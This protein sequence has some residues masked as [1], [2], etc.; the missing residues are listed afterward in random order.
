VAD[1]V[2]DECVIVEVKALDQLHPVHER[3]LHTY[4]KIADCRLGL[5]VNFGQETLKAGIRRV[6][7]RFPEA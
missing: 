6:V 3:Q 4:L 1:L 2:V 5:V 7:N